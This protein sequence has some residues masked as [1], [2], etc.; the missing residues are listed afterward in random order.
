MY[1]TE[2]MID[3]MEQEFPQ[4]EHSGD[5]NRVP[6]AVWEWFGMP[7]RTHADTEPPTGGFF[8]ALRYG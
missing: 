8:D 3:E 5:P 7:K 1:D 6:E 2:R 4:W